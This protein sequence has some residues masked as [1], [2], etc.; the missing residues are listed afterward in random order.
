LAGLII[1]QQNFYLPARDRN[2]LEFARNSY[3]MLGRDML[4]V[5][6]ND[7]AAEDRYDLSRLTC[8]GKS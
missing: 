3:R 6:G 5:A 4:L 1:C 8:Q 7:A 2:L